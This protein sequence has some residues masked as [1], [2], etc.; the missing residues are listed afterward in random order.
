MKIIQFKRGTN[1]PANNSLFDGELYI[2]K[3][4]NSLW[5]GDDTETL[6]GKMFQI[7]SKPTIGVDI[8]NSSG[9]IVNEFITKLDI[10]N[11]GANKPT[12]FRIYKNGSNSYEEKTIS[13]QTS[14]SNATNAQYAQKIG[15][16]SSHPKIGDYNK[17][18]Y[19]NDQGNIT[20]I[21]VTVAD[22]ML[23]SITNGVISRWYGS[24]GSKSQFI[25]YDSIDGFKTSNVNASELNAVNGTS[26]KIA[27][28]LDGNGYFKKIVSVGGKT[29][30]IYIDSNG[31]HQS[32]E[33]SI[34]SV[35]NSSGVQI[36]S[37]GKTASELGITS[38]GI[39][40]FAGYHGNYIVRYEAGK[41]GMSTCCYFDSSDDYKAS[42]ITITTG[43]NFYI[44][45]TK[46][47]NNEPAYGSVSN[48]KI[49]KL[50]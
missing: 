42:F 13:I 40:L 34:I 26:N 19:V 41:V 17:P 3:N 32:C 44:R 9:A 15:T 14:T 31:Q 47:D 20:P 12:V 21:T 36:T 25:F 38:N 8:V 30:P 27:I 24:I 33:G 1:Q 46:W 23:P 28:T 39:Y 37:S 35:I 10:I 43:G 6:S 7:K 48:L 50:A 5:I 45:K 2:D 18:V 22:K 16:S 29:T 11:D 4:A 49:Y